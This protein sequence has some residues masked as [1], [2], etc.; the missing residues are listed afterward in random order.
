M[1]SIHVLCVDE[2]VA[3]YRCMYPA[4]MLALQLLRIVRE[5]VREDDSAA[6]SAVKKKSLEARERSMRQSRAGD[7]KLTLDIKSSNDPFRTTSTSV[8]QRYPNNT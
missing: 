7:R 2:Y 3:R 6:H 5:D 8:L 1:M 4:P